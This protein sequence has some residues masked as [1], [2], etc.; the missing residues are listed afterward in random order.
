MRKVTLAIFS[1]FVKGFFV[2]FHFHWL[3]FWAI[4]LKHI[5]KGFSHTNCH[6][7][8]SEQVLHTSETCEKRWNENK[9]GNNGSNQLTNIH[10]HTWRVRNSRVFAVIVEL[11]MWKTCCRYGAIFRFQ[12]NEYVIGARMCAK[13]SLQ[14]NK[15][16]MKNKRKKIYENCSFTIANCTCSSLTSNS[17]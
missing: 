17:M 3:I 14:A 7:Y 1:L 5:K 13:Y 10:T 2:K 16:F 6:R 15:A 4:K 9:V 12:F 8:D 11:L